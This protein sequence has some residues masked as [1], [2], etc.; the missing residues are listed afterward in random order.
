MGYD[1]DDAYDELYMDNNLGKFLASFMT[2]YSSAVWTFMA[3]CVV[4]L[5]VSLLSVC[6]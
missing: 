3:R 1:Y 4:H 2:R 5:S 6:G